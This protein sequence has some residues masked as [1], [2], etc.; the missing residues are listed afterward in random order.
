[1]SAERILSLFPKLDA[2]RLALTSPQT[3]AYNC[4]AWAA[5]DQKRWWWP[6]ADGI[7]YWPQS[8]QRAVRLIAFQHAFETLGYQITG[9]DS[10][11]PMLEKVTIFSRGAIPTHAAKQLANGLWSSKVG[12]LEDI[13]H[14]LHGIE[15]EAYGT[16]AF[17]MSRRRR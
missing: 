10:L 9:D 16:V 11:E 4:I 13:S 1:M 12:N 15:N 6:D 14:D 2:S 7:A 3:P 5:G 8:V 17:I